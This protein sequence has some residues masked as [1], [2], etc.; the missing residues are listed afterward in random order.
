MFGFEEDFVLEGA[1]SIQPDVR[2][3]IGDL[4]QGPEG[5]PELPKKKRPQIV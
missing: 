3:G 2:F 5:G 4:P 1:F